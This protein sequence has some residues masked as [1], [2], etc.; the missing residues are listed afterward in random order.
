MKN[1]FPAK[2]LLFGEHTILRGSRALAMPL[3]ARYSE[4][5]T[6]GS[7]QQQADLTALADYLEEHF[8]SAFDIQQ[9]RQDLAA[10]SYLASTIPVGYG[11][12]SSGAVCVAV[13]TAY[14]TA[15]GREQ[16]SQQGPKAFF[17]KIESF[18]HG[19]SSGTDPLLSY[20]Q[21]A[22]QLFPDGT[23]QPAT[24]A[25]LP[26]G[27]TLFL[28]D[29]GHARQTAPLV[30][31]FTQRFDQD[32]DFQQLSQREWIAP[33]NQAIDA[34]LT[35]QLEILWNVW[36]MISQF[37]L[38]HLPPMILPAVVDP[39]QK[40]LAGSN[41]LLKICGAGGGGYCLGI[42]RDWVKTQ[43]LLKDWPLLEI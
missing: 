41:Y 3:W 14:A 10:G 16:L 32:Q 28:L 27:W 35:G 7:P 30:Q 23:F 20:L 13:F 26:K 43:V 39:W 25:S 4:W 9:F 34:L 31:Y 1:K 12:G 37:Q 21:E 29:T 5:Q 24:I 11:M 8:P 22:L 15:A 19:T 2:V 6:G 38:T 36:Q 33:T 40:G 42:S 18:F 17:A